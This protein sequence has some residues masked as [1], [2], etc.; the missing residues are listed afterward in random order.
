M[1]FVLL[2]P[3]G[4]LFS[5]EQRPDKKAA[6]LAIPTQINVPIHTRE[7]IAYA[8][9]FGNLS[10][11]EAVFKS[12][13]GLRYQGKEARSIF[14]ETKLSRFTDRET[15]TYDPKTLL[16]LRIERH[17]AIWPYPE[18]IIEEYDQEHFTLTVRKIKG[19][20]KSE[21]LIKKNDVIHNVIL[22]PFILREIEELQE[23]FSLAARLPT[24]E[25]Q[26]QLLGKEKIRVPA[27]EF[28]AYHFVST[29]R[30]FEFWISADEHKV[31]LRIQGLSKAGYVLLMK[32]HTKL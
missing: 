13:P 10:A 28:L 3:V 27:G 2:L 17:I 12:L 21:L 22:L 31:P 15:I 23:G 29:P 8:I 7:R 19:T 14:F 16:P 1:L 26:I 11:G 9:K 4:S 5:L 18:S 6:V 20:H 32:E 30:K 24:Q 25:F